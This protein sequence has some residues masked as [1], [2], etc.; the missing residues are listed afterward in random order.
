[1]KYVISD[2]SPY[3]NVVTQMDRGQN[4][5]FQNGSAAGPNLGNFDRY[6]SGG[7][8]NIFT[9]NEDDIGKHRTILRGCSR[10]NQLI[11]LYLYAE[12]FTN[13]FPDFITDLETVH[14][15]NINE[16]KT[17]KLPALADDEKNDKSI[18]FIDYDLDPLKRYPPFMNYNNFT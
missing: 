13:S 2:K 10:F 9:Q 3:G 1:M 17:Y 16:T 4:W 7:T 12:V 11:E 15:V 14:I 5:L 8:F 6:D 18:V